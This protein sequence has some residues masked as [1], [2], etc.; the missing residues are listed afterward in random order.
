MLVPYAASALLAASA[1]LAAPAHERRSVSFKWG[2]EP[3]RG[4]SLGGWLVLEPFITPSIFDNKTYNAD[5]TIVDE[6]TLCKTL[7][8]S[9]AKSILQPHWDSW[10][11]LSDFQKI[12][13]AKLNM[14]RIPI[15]HWAF[16]TFDNEPYV[17]GAA[18][19]LDKAI[20]WARQTGLKVLID[21]HTAPLS[22]NGYDNSG[23][24][25]DNPGW[26]QGDSVSQTLSVLQQIANKYAQASYQD[27]ILGIELLNEPAGYQLDMGTIKQFFRDGYGNVRTVS[28]TPVVLHDAFQDANTFNGWMT[29]S[30]NNVQ[31]VAMDHHEYQ[32]FE[33][34]YVT[35]SHAE[36]RQQV[37]DRADAYYGSDK[38]S[39]VGEWTAAMTD[40]AP[41]LNGYGRGARYDGS[42]EDAPWTGSCSGVSDIG[43]W[44]QGMKDD[45]RWYIETQMDAFEKID[46]WIFWN[47][48]TEGAAEW[49]LFGLLDAG[50]FPNPPTDRKFASV[51]G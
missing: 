8:A 43:T 42:Y 18:A 49:D 10:V 48:K 51:C 1:A 34:E 28:D 24:R 25:M 20:G 35:W 13:N 32:V 3:L 12:A 46:G 2:E 22:Q 19:Y 5:G 37:C 44:D 17:S 7:G 4:V 45:T 36:H 26:T 30:D 21:L 29:P 14:V 6:Y 15:G 27:V 38:W 39:Y 31:N 33:N 11:S 41:Y 16:Q 50:V 9:E 40:C 47:F 23:Q